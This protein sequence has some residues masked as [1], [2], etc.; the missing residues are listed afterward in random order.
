MYVPEH[1][2]ATGDELRYNNSNSNNKRATARLSLI[3]QMEVPDRITITGGDSYGRI[4]EDY[5]R[6]A[7]FP[8]EYNEALKD[9][10]NILTVADTT[11]PEIQ[12]N[13]GRTETARTDNSMVVDEDPLRELKTLRRQMGRLN[14]RVFYLE[15]QNEKRKNRENML[16]LA[17]LG[18]ALTAVWSLFKH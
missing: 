2:T 16:F 4:T 5:Q 15:D 8:T 18:V 6:G 12:D 13:Q 10:P 14:A 3:E 7:R 1:I 17:F 11:Y 9:V